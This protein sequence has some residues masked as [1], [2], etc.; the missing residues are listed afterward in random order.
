MDASMLR[1]R[2][3]PRSMTCL[4]G[5]DARAP[6]REH[7]ARIAA[8]PGA[9]NAILFLSPFRQYPIRLTEQQVQTVLR[10]VHESF[11]AETGVRLFGSRTNDDA[12]GGDID[13]LIEL[14]KKATLKKEIALAARL[15]DQLGRPVD[16]VTTWPGQSD[17]PIV[18]I[19]RL[20]GIKL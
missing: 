6:D 15:E 16:V 19:A 2:F 10:L 11:G 18:E 3:A 17:R 8:T 12:H 7:L 9:V 1:L 5:R 13:L 20:T 14:P 4:C